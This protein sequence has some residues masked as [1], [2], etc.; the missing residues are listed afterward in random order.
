MPDVSARWQVASPS[1]LVRRSWAEGES[2]VFQPASGDLHLLNPAA[3]AV[4]DRLL[5]GSASLDELCA[6][7]DTEERAQMRDLLDQLDS[8]GLVNPVFPST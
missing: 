5:A 3:T 8:L 2:V 4:L 1:S 6:S 7:D